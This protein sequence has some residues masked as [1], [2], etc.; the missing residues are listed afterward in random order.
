LELEVILVD[1]DGT[2]LGRA[3]SGSG[4]SIRTKAS[5]TLIERLSADPAHSYD[6]E[7]MLGQGRQ[8]GPS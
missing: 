1:F 6:D 8:A 2:V 5:T 3:R 4:Q 7:A